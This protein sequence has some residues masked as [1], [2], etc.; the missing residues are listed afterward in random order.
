MSAL[1]LLIMHNKR[2]HTWRKG[3]YV[4]MNTTTTMLP[5]KRP[6]H[7]LSDDLTAKL[8]SLH[9]CICSTYWTCS[10]LLHHTG[11]HFIHVSPAG[12]GYS[13]GQLGHGL[14]PHRF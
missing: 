5:S 9:H 3:A 1:N 4:S 7:K 8:V 10:I 11:Q 12:T 6:T 14:G 13:T 2:L